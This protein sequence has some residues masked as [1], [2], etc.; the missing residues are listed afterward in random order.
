MIDIENTYS[1]CVCYDT[2]EYFKMQTVCKHC[3]CIECILQLNKL[4][5]PLCRSKFPEN[6][7]NSLMIYKR[8]HI[9][10]SNILMNIQTFFYERI[11]YL[12]DC[13]NRHRCFIL[14]FV[15]FT[16]MLI[17][18]LLKVIGIL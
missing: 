15:L 3:I 18:Y 7:A 2:Q 5:C 17:L 8:S 14:I 9:C 4:Q 16:A 1:C 13:L 12:Y 6:I 10:E 11:H